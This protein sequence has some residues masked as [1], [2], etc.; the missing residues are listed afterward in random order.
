[1]HSTLLIGRIK[2]QSSAEA[3]VARLFDAFDQTDMPYR[4]STRRRELFTYRG[5]YIH[6]QDFEKENGSSSI[7]AARSDPR[8]IQIS[9]DLKAYLEAYDPATWRSPAD[10]MATRF[11]HWQASG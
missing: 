10:A 5:L 4:M 2:P 8:F 9:A 11:Y 6:M 1:M 7:Q 3:E